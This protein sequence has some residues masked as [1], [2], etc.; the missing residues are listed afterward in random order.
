MDLTD[1]EGAWEGTQGQRGQQTRVSERGHRLAQV[2]V[3]SP[4]APWVEGREAGRPRS[5]RGSQMGQSVDFR[6][7]GGR[8]PAGI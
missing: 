7:H 5:R 6:C 1:K 4:G 3:S 2:A 8:R